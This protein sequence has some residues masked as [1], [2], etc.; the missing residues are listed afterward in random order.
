MSLLKEKMAAAIVASGV[1]L[2]PAAVLAEPN[3]IPP[4]ENYF[5]CRITF[6]GVI[7]EESNYVGL[8]GK[9]VNLATFAI[10][11]CASGEEDYTLLI[12]R[13]IIAEEVFVQ[14]RLDNIDAALVDRQRFYLE[15]YYPDATQE[16]AIEI[17]EH[18]RDNPYIPT[19]VLLQA[20]NAY[21]AVLC[22]S[23]E[24]REMEL[25]YIADLINPPSVP[26]NAFDR[27]NLH[28]SVLCP[29]AF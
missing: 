27:N 19:L 25:D 5:D 2:S 10:T 15:R 4:E 29:L 8:E 22:T 17:L 12:S 7:E 16:S 6:Q 3:D 28:P 9:A 26:Y 14:D 23:G 18:Q 20:F 1:A 13:R 24:Y 11:D 21:S